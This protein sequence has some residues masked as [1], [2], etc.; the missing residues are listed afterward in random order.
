MCGSR[1]LRPRW[2][3]SNRR[4]GALTSSELVSITETLS[5]RS[6]RQRAVCLR[7]TGRIRVAR[8]QRQI[9]L[10]TIV[11]SV[12][13]T[14]RLVGTFPAEN[15]NPIGHRAN[16]SQ[17][18][19]DRGGAAASSPAG[20]QTRPGEAHEKASSSRP[21]VAANG[22]AGASRGSSTEG[23]DQH[24]GFSSV[25]SSSARPVDDDLVDS[26]LRAETEVDAI[27]VLRKIPRAGDIALPSACLPPAI[28]L[29]R[30]R[31]CRRD[32]FLSPSA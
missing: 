26:W 20:A 16:S 5:A 18:E 10:D 23:R 7:R 22:F 27:I 31:Q 12:S 30:A 2:R 17:L 11:R 29:R 9:R 13:T 19:W 4:T 14:R 1:D 25:C 21:Q 6:W 8:G 24:L 15:I 28:I 32:C 3:G